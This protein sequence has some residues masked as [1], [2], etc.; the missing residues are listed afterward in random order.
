MLERMPMSRIQVNSGKIFHKL[1]TECFADQR[2]ATDIEVEMLAGEIWRS[3][4]GCVSGQPWS[5]VARGSDAYKRMIKA[6]RGALGLR[7]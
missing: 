2:P 6:A 1:L 7:A 5:D 3:S 4:H